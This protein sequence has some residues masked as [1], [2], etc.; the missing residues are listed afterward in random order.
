MSRD[1]ANNLNGQGAIST[2]GRLYRPKAFD[3]LDNRILTH[4]FVTCS[5]EGIEVQALVDTGS[6]RSFI[7][8]DVYT[9]MDF[10]NVRIDKSDLEKCR[11]ITGGSLDIS[12]RIKGN[13]KFPSSKQMY[14]CKFLI[15]N[16]IQ[17][18]CVL[19]WDFLVAN[20]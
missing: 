7:N 19:G 12:G 3:A 6:M 9:I 15:S 17:Y 4:P 16:N 20:S 10:N 18:D 8:K 1:C 13:I 14:S 11:S 2:G 5:I